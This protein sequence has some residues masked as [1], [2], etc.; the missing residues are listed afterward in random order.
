[1]TFVG[2][3]TDLFDLTLVDRQVK[4][5]LLHTRYD[6]GCPSGRR[7]WHSPPGPS[8]DKTRRNS[9]ILRCRP[10][11]PYPPKRRALPYC[12]TVGSPT[13]LGRVHTVL[14]LCRTQD[15]PK[16][17]R[18]NYILSWKKRRNGCLPN[19][20]RR[21]QER[22]ENMWDILVFPRSCGWQYVYY[23][24]FI[25]VPKFLLRLH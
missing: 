10:C 1:M 7:R 11:L 22:R 12:R 24:N 15:G 16:S 5:E 17:E 13:V 14:E 6:T 20:Y 2:Y 4:T 8:G 25:N 9:K 18:I 3:T 23:V 21:R 19:F